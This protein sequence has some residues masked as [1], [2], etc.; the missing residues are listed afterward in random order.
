MYNKNRAVA[1][2]KYERSRTIQESCGTDKGQG[3][4]GGE[5]PIRYVVIDIS[6]PY[7]DYMP[8]FAELLYDSDDR[9]RMEAP[10]IFRVLGK[11]RPEFVNPYIGQLR[12]VADTDKNRIV[13][14]HSLGAIRSAGSKD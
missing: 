10:E 6:D 14:I 5:Y 4:V 13:R 11:R 9:V 3:T 8:L 7:K 1:L 12:N 2:L